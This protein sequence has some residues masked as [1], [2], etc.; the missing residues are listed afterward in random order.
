VGSRLIE[1]LIWLEAGTFLSQENIIKRQK[2]STCRFIK[3]QCKKT[4]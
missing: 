1:Y 3:S 2:Y 4:I